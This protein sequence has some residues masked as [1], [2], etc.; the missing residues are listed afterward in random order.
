M[1]MPLRHYG[2]KGMHWG[3]RR[4]NPTSGGTSESG[5]PSAH[6]DAVRVANSRAKA[7]RGSTDALST[8]ELQELVLRMNLEQQYSR[9]A[10]SDPAS[11]TSAQ[12]FL[13]GTVKTVK[14]AQ[15]VYQFAN[16]PLGKTLRTQLKKQ[17]T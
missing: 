3:V 10:A 1:N 8:K 12:K 6:E 9:I 16:S 5:H 15:A 14:T 11:K 13:N 17:L 4:S 2:I 7:H